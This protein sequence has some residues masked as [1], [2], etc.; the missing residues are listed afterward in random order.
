LSADVF[1]NTKNEKDKRIRKS[2][3]YLY[4]KTKDVLGYVIFDGFNAGG[5]SATFALDTSYHILWTPQSGRPGLG[6]VM[7]P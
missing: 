5:I 7:Y 6:S 3:R 1:V 4:K 2:S